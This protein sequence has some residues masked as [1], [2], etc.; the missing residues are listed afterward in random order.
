MGLNGPPRVTSYVNDVAR[1]CRL[2]GGPRSEP[3]VQRGAPTDV[4]VSVLG[5]GMAV[6][7]G[8]RDTIYFCF[9]TARQ[10]LRILRLYYEIMGGQHM[11]QGAVEGVGVFRMPVTARALVGIVAYGCNAPVDRVTSSWRLCIHQL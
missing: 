6:I 1:R 2:R 11:P 3:Y 8:R 5:G 7:T 9:V 4:Q 10:T